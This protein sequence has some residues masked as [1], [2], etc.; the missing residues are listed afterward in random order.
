MKIYER[1]ME[2]AVVYF[3]MIVK[4]WFG[5]LVFFFKRNGRADDDI[6]VVVE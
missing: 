5:I 1:I 6:E 4:K 3:Y 2:K